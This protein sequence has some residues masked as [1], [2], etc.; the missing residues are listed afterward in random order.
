M[1]SRGGALKA[2][3]QHPVTNANKRFNY[4]MSPIRA[5]VEHVLRV[6]K[7]QFG[8]TKVR[9]KGI[10][11]NSAHMFSLIGLSSPLSGEASL[12]ALM[13]EIHSTYTKVSARGLKSLEK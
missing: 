1:C 13:G 2:R 5:R 4:K 9:Y 12:D 7:R 8:C 10:A 6:I 11:E 3:K